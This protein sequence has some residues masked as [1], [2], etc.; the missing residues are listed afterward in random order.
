LRRTLLYLLEHHPDLSHWSAADSE[1]QYCG[2]KGNESKAISALGVESIMVELRPLVEKMG[3]DR[4]G[5]TVALVR[6]IFKIVKVGIPFE[7]L[8]K[9]VYEAQ[10]LGHLY[11]LVSLDEE[12]RELHLPATLDETGTK[13]ELQAELS[14][15]WNEVMLL[16]RRHRAA[17]LLNLRDAHGDSMIRLIPVL[18]IASMRQIAKCLEISIEDLSAIWNELPWDDNQ[19]A[20]L[21]GVERQ[22]VINLRSSAR[23]R[24][25]RRLAGL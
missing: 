12:T 8:L 21:L 19:I 15:V 25:K 5:Q 1:D 14:L 13:L 7:I 6:E 22:Q 2:F 10:G 24:L 16:S 23:L 18:S 9:V 11:G 20:D 4:Q 3:L 17:I